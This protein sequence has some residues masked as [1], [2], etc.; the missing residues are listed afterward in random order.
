VHRRALAIT[1]AALFVPATAADA[2]T[3]STDADTPRVFFHAD[4]GERNRV[5]IRTTAA[6]L[7]VRDSGSRIT[8]GRGCASVTR[9]EA[10]CDSTWALRSNLGDEDDTLRTFGDAPLTTTI[11]GPGDDVLLGGDEHDKLF[12]GPGR[13]VLRGRADVDRLVGGPGDDVIDG[14]PGRDVVE[15]TSHPRGVSV[16]LARGVAIS[17]GGELDQITGIE[18]VIGGPGDDRL[19]GDASANQLDGGGGRNRLLGREGRDSFIRG[20]GDVS[21]GDGRDMVYA[22]ASDP[23]QFVALDCEWIEGSGRLQFAQADV[24]RPRWVGWSVSCPSETPESPPESCAPTIRL[25][26]VGGRRR[27]LAE[28]ALA[29]APWFDRLVRLRLNRIGRRLLRTAR[30]PRVTVELTIPDW[31]ALHWRASLK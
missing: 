22:P 25:S 9:H 11:G 19:A 17:G 31:N 4:P 15:Y 10:R 14:G 18:D 16:D 21:C 6:G 24:V 2:S 5:E 28:V 13:D 3:L 8:A 1:A 29:S 23:I 27:T 7:E 12:G 26:E 30:D 20:A